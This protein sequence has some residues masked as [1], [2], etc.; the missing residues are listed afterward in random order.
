MAIE[1][2]DIQ[3][4]SNAVNQR[5]QQYKEHYLGEPSFYQ[6]FKNVLV[7]TF[8]QIRQASPDVLIK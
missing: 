1:F 7:N 2:E 8:Y 6:A 4:A 3:N 5:V